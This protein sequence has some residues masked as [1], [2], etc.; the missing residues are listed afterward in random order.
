[1]LADDQHK[2]LPSCSRRCTAPIAH[3]HATQQSCQCVAVAIHVALEHIRR[4]SI[5]SP[6]SPTDLKTALIL[7][8]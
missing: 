6:E 2:A 3:L 1:M 8:N 5:H 7:R 4:F